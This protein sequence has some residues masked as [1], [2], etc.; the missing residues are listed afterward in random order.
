MTVR[1]FF[2]ETLAHASYLVGDA[3][4]AVVIDPNRDL[5]S[6]LAAAAEEGL[7]I[8]AVAETHIHADYASGA[9]ELASRTGATLYVSDEGPTDWKYEF[10]SEPGVLPVRNGAKIRVGNVSLEVV[11]TPGHTPEHISFVLSDEA[12]E[13]AAFTGDFLFVGD[14][15]RPDLLERAAGIEGTME[16]GARVLHN[17]IRRFKERF[18][19]DLLIWPAHGAGSACGKSLGN[20]PV[21]TLGIENRA[22]W[23][24]RVSDEAE[25]V[26]EILAGQP[27]P[28]SYFKE[29][30]RINKLRPR[31]GEPKL[32][33]IPGDALVEALDR[34]EVVID[35]RSP[36]EVAAGSLAGAINL[37][38]DRSFTNWAGWFLPYDREVWL[39]ANRF[40]DVKL[41]AE[42]LAL[43]G[44][45]RIAGWSGV[46]ALRA[47][48]RRHGTLA[49]TPPVSLSELKD[50]LHS[51]EVEAVDVRAATEYAA[52]HIPGAKHVFLGTAPEAA[53]KLDPDKPV[54]VYCGGGSRAFIGASLLVRAGIK[55]VMTLPAGF[56]D[57]KSLGMPIEVEAPEPAKV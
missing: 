10:A 16:A 3:G 13:V 47:Y 4:E 25:F 42:R 32:D 39:V 7:R 34:G 48:E 26:R 17:T 40:E 33:R 46:E 6:Y 23:A 22:N 35:V 28:P 30:K 1:R 57:W 36:G 54:V 37:P 49:V 15:G 50:R 8:V 20:V 31:F 11:A 55:S 12:G 51:G 41:A 38:L 9:Y 18:E 14:V 45:H 21:S 29:M 24:F 56:A 27:E 2:E 52:G 43:I 53:R 44:I 5:E 19:D